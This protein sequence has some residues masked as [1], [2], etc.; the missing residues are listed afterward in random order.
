VKTKKKF[1][2]SRKLGHAKTP[3]GRYSP[4]AKRSIPLNDDIRTPLSPTSSP[5]ITAPP[6]SPP[7]E[8]SGD[9]GP[10]L[11]SPPD[12]SPSPVTN[13]PPANK[14]KAEKFKTTD[15][16]NWC[17]R[18][19]VMANRELF[20]WQQIRLLNIAE[21]K[22][23]DYPQGFDKGNYFENLPPIIASGYERAEKITC[24]EREHAGRK[25]PCDQ[26]QLCSKCAY[27]RGVRATEMYEGTFGKT[28]LYHVT[29]SFEGGIPFGPTNS[30]AAQEYWDANQ[31]GIKNLL[32]NDL[33]EGAYLSH[34][35][36]IRSLHPLHV[37]PHTHVIVSA[38][39]FPDEVKNE[40]FKFIAAQEGVDL[41]PSIEVKLI[42]S[43]QYHDKC[44]RYL[45]KAIDLQEPYLTAWRKHCEAD[46]KLAPTLN[47]QMRIFL[48]AQAAA[49]QGIDKVIRFGN[50]MPQRKNFI[51]VSA[52]NREAKRKKKKNSKNKLPPPKYTGRVKTA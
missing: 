29:L 17:D 14:S 46:R 22:R 44:F 12:S 26:W 24:C 32:A 2:P 10:A 28:P 52:A 40:L 41:K 47:R 6:S 34:E 13:K 33:I 35:L 49:S 1:G 45:T 21:T 43:K 18:E 27:I 37:N 23:T 36:K 19:E 3:Q 5:L 30:V 42:D 25:I 48:D 16:L 7:N 9:D 38:S 50:L 31:K 15:E 11:I 20:E 4:S 39:K 51:G 8:C